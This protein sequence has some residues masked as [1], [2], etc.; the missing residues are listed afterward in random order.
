MSTSSM[1]DMSRRDHIATRNVEVRQPQQMLAVE[2][3]V[4]PEVA[5]SARSAAQQTTLQSRQE[6]KKK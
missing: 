2:Q 3:T 1:L 4:V 5:T 6:D